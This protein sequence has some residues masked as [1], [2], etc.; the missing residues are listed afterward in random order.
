MSGACCRRGTDKKCIQN[1]R[2]NSERRSLRV[3]GTRRWEDN[4]KMDFRRKCGGNCG[5][6]AYDSGEG[7]V[8]GFCEHG[9]ELSGSIKGLA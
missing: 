5:H 7:P 9:Y 6:D 3:R 1:F 4:I 2:R 8:A